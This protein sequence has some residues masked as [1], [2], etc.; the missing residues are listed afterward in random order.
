MTSAHAGMYARSVCMVC[1]LCLQN[2]HHNM[3]QRCYSCS[4]AC[5]EDDGHK[6]I[7]H[8]VCLTSYSSYQ[9][10]ACAYRAKGAKETAMTPRV[11]T[12]RQAAPC[13]FS[14][15][16]LRR[17]V[18]WLPGRRQLPTVL[19]GQ[20]PPGC[21]PGVAARQQQVRP[22]QRHHHLPTLPL[23]VLFCFLFLSLFLPVS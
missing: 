22:G 7:H 3:P 2:S 16:W 18:S 15:T 19:T 1:R 6:S 8:S 4:S 10:C 20:L 17:R 9:S 12:S 14:R 21:R 11:Q 5:T 23:F 13:T